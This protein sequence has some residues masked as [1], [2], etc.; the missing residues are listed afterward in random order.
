MCRP[1]ARDLELLTDAILKHWRPS[2]EV[3]FENILLDERN[4]SQARS[5]DGFM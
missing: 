1:E 5:E 2:H 4:I 3:N